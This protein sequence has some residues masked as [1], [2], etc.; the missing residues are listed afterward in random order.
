MDIAKIVENGHFDLHL[1]TTA[2]DGVL[3]PTEIVELAMSKGITTIAITDH[4]TLRGIREAE[5]AG[6]RYGV[7]VIP[8]IEISTK[9]KGT[10]IDILGYGIKEAKLMNETLQ[11]IREHREKRA[12]LIMNKFCELGMNIAEEDIKQHIV[13]DVIAR[14]T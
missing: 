13:G 9:H 4:D 5:E 11:K 2:S 10:N 6:K 1:H 8:G 7:K 12:K 3:T 14:P